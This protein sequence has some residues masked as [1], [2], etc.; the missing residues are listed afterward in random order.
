MELSLMFPSILKD[1]SLS[2]LHNLN[3]FSGNVNDCSDLF[4]ELLA[5]KEEFT[6]GMK[7]NWYGNTLLTK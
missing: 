5:I 6:V 1:I 4:Q 3:M 7:R 2:Q